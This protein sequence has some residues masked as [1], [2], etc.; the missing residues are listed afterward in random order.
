M[1]KQ[2]KTSNSKKET[3]KRAENKRFERQRTSKRK[4]KFALER[5]KNQ[6]IVLRNNMTNAA[7][8]YVDELKETTT[9]DADVIPDILKDL[10]FDEDKKLDVLKEPLEDGK[11]VNR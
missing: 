5:R 8:E 1:K 4:I 9:I 10:P 2:Q 3:L 11:L 7:K 6:L